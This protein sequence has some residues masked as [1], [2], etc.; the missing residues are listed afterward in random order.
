MTNDKTMIEKVARAIYASD[1]ISGVDYDSLKP[2]IKLK[3]EIFASAALSVMPKQLS[4][5]EAVEVMAM[6]IH[7]MAGAW[8]K[9]TIIEEQ[10]LAYR[11]LI[12]AQEGK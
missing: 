11:A 4:E 1:P 3:I 7:P 10:K 9:C 12:K 2:H 8:A 5:E 6:A